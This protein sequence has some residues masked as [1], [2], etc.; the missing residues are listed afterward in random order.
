MKAGIRDEDIARAIHRHA[1]WLRQSGGR[2]SSL[3][4]AWRNFHY[5]L[6]AGIRNEKIS[7]AIHR[8]TLRL[9]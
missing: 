3:D 9:R 6:A 7:C 8:D 1:L 2:H 5:L 4:A